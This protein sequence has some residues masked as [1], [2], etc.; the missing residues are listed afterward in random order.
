MVAFNLSKFRLADLE[1]FCDNRLDNINVYSVVLVTN[2]VDF[3]LIISDFCQRM[4]NISYVQMIQ[5][6]ADD[7]TRFTF[8]SH[9]DCYT[10]S[11]C[12]HTIVDNLSYIYKCQ[13]NIL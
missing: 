4:K 2:S 5:K 10:F 8:V 6:S 7:F 13:I 1:F 9:V 3:D 12:L 11:K